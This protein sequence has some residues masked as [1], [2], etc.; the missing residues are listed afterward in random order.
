MPYDAEH[1]LSKDETI[2]IKGFTIDTKES[3]E[4]NKSG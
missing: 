3:I 1:D 4:E 2:S